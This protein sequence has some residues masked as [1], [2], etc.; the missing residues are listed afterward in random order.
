[1]MN[2]IKQ[3]A[4]LVVCLLATFGL[5]YNYINA[6]SLNPIQIRSLDQVPRLDDQQRQ[7]GFDYFLLA[8][9]WPN[10]FCNIA[11]HR[12]PPSHGLKRQ[13][14]P[15][16]PLPKHQNFTIHGLWPQLNIGVSPLSCST[17]D[18]MTNKILSKF[19]EELLDYWPNLNS[20]KDFEKS[21]W[22]W[23]HEWNKHGSCSSNKFTP[24]KYLRIS[25]DLAKSILLPFCWSWKKQGS[26]QMELLHIV[27]QM[28]RRQ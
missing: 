5:Y 12:K 22:F 21:K 3:L 7:P 26:I 28:Y 6:T 15:D 4:L 17:T 27:M 18:Q 20:A 24:D 10:A 23:R 1:M 13:C 19:K 9:Q 11:R 8:L 16:H 2:I 14:D 25:L